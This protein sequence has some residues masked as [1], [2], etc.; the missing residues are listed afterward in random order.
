MDRTNRSILLALAAVIGLTIAALIAAVLIPFE[1]DKPASV[2]TFTGQAN[3]VA[4]NHVTE[5]LAEDSPGVRLRL[6]YTLRLEPESSARVTFELNQGW[7]V[8]TGPAALK[9]TESHRRATLLGHLLGAERFTREYA[10]TIEQ[11]QGTVRYNFA[12]TDPPFEDLDITL[13][14]PDRT[15]QPPVPCWQIEVSADG[16]AATQ[17]E[18]CS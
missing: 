8:L 13:R 12:H 16:T 9:I 7:A 18:P 15:Y 6:D 4:P 1:V 3:L 11:T 10:L 5:T 14:L 17:T 2:D